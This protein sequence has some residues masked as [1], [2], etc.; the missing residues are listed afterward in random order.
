M[1]LSVWVLSVEV[2][3]ASVAAAGSHFLKRSASGVEPGLELAGV[4][5]QLSQ[6][7]VLPEDE[8][9]EE[10]DEEALSDEDDNDDDEA[11]QLAVLT[12]AG[13]LL[14]EAEVSQLGVLAALAAE[15]ASAAEAEDEAE[16]LELSAEL[17]A[18]LSCLASEAAT[19]AR[20]SA[21]TA[22]W[23]SAPLLPPEAAG[24]PVI[25]PLSRGSVTCWGLY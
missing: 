23:S 24:S 11:S 2:A 8:E 22:E 12:V 6:L 20:A 16:E 15:A 17:D 4:G 5:F 21:T 14:A 1:V 7:G 18:L 10:L 9:E 13:V 3:V 25:I 19:S